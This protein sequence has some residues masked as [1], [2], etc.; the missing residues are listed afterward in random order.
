MNMEKIK[1]LIVE[2]KEIIA[3]NLAA[4]L[5]QHSFELMATVS[6]GEEAVRLA[7]SHPPDLILMD[8]QL[9]GA[10]DG[11]TAAATIRKQHDIPVIYLSDYADASTVER[12]KVTRP[13][14]YL[15]KPFQ[16]AELVRTLDIAFYNAN[17]QRKPDPKDPRD[18]M[19]RVN[20]V[21]IKLRP[22]DILYLEAD[23]AYCRLI[24]EKGEH[25]VSH[26][27]NHIYEQLDDRLFIRVH[28]S[29]VINKEKIAKIDGNVLYLGSH[30]VQMS[31]EYK[32]EVTKLFHFIK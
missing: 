18:L 14:A 7:L 21:Y 2:D 22:A 24:T 30:K 23:R 20:Q 15:T 17:A 6:T 25:L 4:L 5:T 11:I 8:I 13:A 31:K 32:E 10:M 19:L 29:H 27:M 26:S 3:A 16:D 1:V 9:A 12:A 28:R